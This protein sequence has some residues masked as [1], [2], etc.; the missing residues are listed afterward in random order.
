MEQESKGVL[1]NLKR[2]IHQRACEGHILLLLENG[3]QLVN[4]Q[5]L[6]NSFLSWFD[7]WGRACVLER[8]NNVRDA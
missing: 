6:Q 7:A 8:A 2:Q 1:S 4:W 5:S 3:G